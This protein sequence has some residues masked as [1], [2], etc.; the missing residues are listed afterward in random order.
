[1]S[2]CMPTENEKQGLCEHGLSILARCGKCYSS[3]S[4]I[5]RQD[6]TNILFKDKIKSLE[7]HYIRQIDENRKISRR[8]NE[9]ESIVNKMYNLASQVKGNQFV[10]NDEN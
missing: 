9:L 7:E 4:E 8:V 10:N 2:G 3:V 6:E 5:I 1:M